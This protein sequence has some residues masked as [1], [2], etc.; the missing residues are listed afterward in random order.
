MVKL[1]RSAKRRDPA[2]MRRFNR[3]ARIPAEPA[4]DVYS[5]GSLLYELL[6]GMTVFDNSDP[7]GTGTACGDLQAPDD[8]TA[9]YPAQP[10]GHGL[11]NAG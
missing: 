11:L 6:T 8:G 5:T 3:E 1:I 7:A 4:S 10:A 9:S 2:A